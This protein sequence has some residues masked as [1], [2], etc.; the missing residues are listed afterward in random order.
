L[1]TRHEAVVAVPDRPGEF[2]RIT[3]ALADANV[4]IKDFE[5]LGVRESGGAVRIAFEDT[6]ALDRGTVV[7]QD[8]GYE[9][10]TRNGAP[11]S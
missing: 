11:P 1:P 6:N 8:A 5:V 7:L 3:A 4:N 10:R 9:V 2:A